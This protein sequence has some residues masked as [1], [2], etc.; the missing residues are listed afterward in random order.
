MLSN[1]DVETT[2]FEGMIRQVKLK[3]KLL[4]RDVEMNLP[5]ILTSG[6]RRA[7]QEVE[8][9][10]H[11]RFYVISVISNLIKWCR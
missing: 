10:T 1:G 2:A 5:L 6:Y 7:T 11:F 4:G 8:L 3:V 9:D